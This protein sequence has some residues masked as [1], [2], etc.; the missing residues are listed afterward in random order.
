ML[1]FS[2]ERS[3]PFVLCNKDVTIAEFHVEGRGVLENVV[4][5]R[6]FVKMPC[7]VSDLGSF[8]ENRKAPK[9]RRNIRRLLKMSGCDTLLG[10]LEITYALTLTDACWVKPKDSGLD[11]KSV[12]LYSH[13]FNKAVAEI[14]L[15]GLSSGTGLS[16]VS[17]EYGT[18]GTF[19]KCWIRENGVIKLLKKGSSGARNAGL[20]PYSEFYVSQ[21]AEALGLNHVTYGLRSRSGKVCSVCDAF[22]SESIGYVPFAALDLRVI[23]LAGVLKRMQTYGLQKEAIDM[24]IFDAV[25]FNEDRHKG[26]FGILVNNDTQEVV[27]AAPL[28]DHNVAMLCYAE[29]EDFA[30]L[31]KYLKTKGPRIGNDFVQDARALLYPG[32]KKKLQRL[33]GFSFKRHPEIN[34]PEERLKL[35]ENAVNRQIRLILE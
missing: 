32:M 27:G 31:P 12:S 7:W 2:Q 23:D 17:P 33:L 26:N 13:E 8:I 34:L 15:E 14:A 1:G 5:D 22:T 24:F 9:E 6:Q 25:I 4:I 16:T 10:W 11:W 19:A 18:D 30:D 28:F 3:E 35:L 20:E 21:I 29:E